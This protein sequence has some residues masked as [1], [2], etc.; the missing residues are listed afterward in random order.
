MR[1]LNS[2]FSTSLGLQIILTLAAFFAL[3]SA[4][5]AEHF[6]KLRPCSLCLF[7]QYGFIIICLGGCVAV[8]LTFLK[9]HVKK[10][11]LFLATLYMINAGIAFYQVAVEHRWVEV[12][13]QCQNK[14]LF[15]NSI[16][17]LREQLLNTETVRCDQVQWSL[18]GISMAGYN[19]LYCLFW[20]LFSLYFLRK[21][22]TERRPL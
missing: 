2:F 19:A 15:G 18:F 4:Y 6:F 7:Q 16:E 1:K 20:G 11:S 10:I 22:K 14:K 17:E 5:S 3:L 9:V 13:T 12:P 21:Q 8:V